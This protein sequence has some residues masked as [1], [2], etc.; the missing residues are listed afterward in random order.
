MVGSNG[1]L[2]AIEVGVKMIHRFDNNQ[3]FT[4]GCAIF[5][6]RF[7]YR[8]VAV[9]SFDSCALGGLETEWHQCQH[10]WHHCLT[11]RGPRF[12]ANTGADCEGFLEAMK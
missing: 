1:E 8:S 9:I 6:F 2:P 12:Q 11:Q 7:A 3:K 4:P 5:T 10:C